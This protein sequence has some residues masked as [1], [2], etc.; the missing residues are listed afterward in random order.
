MDADGFDATVEDVDALL[1]KLFEP[2]QR[3]SA[4]EQLDRL[5]S[6]PGLS[7]G[8]ARLK[9]AA[10]LDSQG[11]WDRLVE[12][13]DLGLVDWRDLLVRAFYSDR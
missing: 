2:Q 11:S 12:A 5:E 3:A 13:V 1:T 10:L 8:G 6:A 4:R 7:G 9:V